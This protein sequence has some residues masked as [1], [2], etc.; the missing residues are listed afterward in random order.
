MTTDATSG[1]GATPVDGSGTGSAGGSGSRKGPII[2]VVVVVVLVLAGGGLFWF[3]R[4]DAPPPVSLETA[5]KGVEGGNGAG[6]SGSA[7]SGAAVGD[8][9]GTWTVDAESGEV[10]Y[11]SATGSFAGFRVEEELTIGSATA[12][13]RTR[14]VSG[15]IVIEGNTLTSADIT[16]DLS[17][18][19]T[20]DSR[21]DGKA[22]DA[23]DTD[24]FPDAT[25]VLTEAVDFGDPAAGPVSVQ[26]TGDLTIKGVTQSV[27]IPLEAQ[28]VDGTIVVVGSVP[29][30]FA[31]YGVEPPKAPI[32]LSVAPEGTLELQLLFTQS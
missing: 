28:V 10:D 26:A 11:E 1:G 24:A 12:V 15:E 2:A 7:S 19:T 20:N 22:R 30:T 5:T 8:V 29:I 21:R 18:L 25:F 31:D 16:A 14:D 23:L 4:D 17:T 13:G 27:T 32:V 6:S 3:L 9:S